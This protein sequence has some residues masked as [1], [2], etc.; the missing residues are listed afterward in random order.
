VEAKK[1]KERR[2][3]REEEKQVVVWVVRDDGWCGRG[4]CKECEHRLPVQ[5]GYTRVLCMR[6]AVLF[7]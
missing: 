5:I 4:R 1:R 3:G 7:Q 6:Y 2:R